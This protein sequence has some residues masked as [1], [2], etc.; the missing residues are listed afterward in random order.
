MVESICYRIK[1]DLS[2]KVYVKSVSRDIDEGVKVIY[3]TILTYFKIVRCQEEGAIAEYFSANQQTDVAVREVI[4]SAFFFVYIA[5]HGQA[6]WYPV[7]HLSVKIRII[8]R[9]QKFLY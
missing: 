8:Q 2:A 7:G 3:A 9:I 1:T 6:A 4:Y 5:P